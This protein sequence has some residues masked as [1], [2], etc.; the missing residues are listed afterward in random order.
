MDRRRYCKVCP[1]TFWITVLKKILT[2]VIGPVTGET[3]EHFGINANIVATE[4]TIEGLVEAVKK[5][6]K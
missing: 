2:A 5:Y 6:Y 3:L 4:Y 1:L